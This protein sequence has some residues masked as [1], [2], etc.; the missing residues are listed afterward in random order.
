[1]GGGRNCGQGGAESPQLLV[2]KC[3]NPVSLHSFTLLLYYNSFMTNTTRSSCSVNLNAHSTANAHVLAVE[4]V[5]LR[6][7]SCLPYSSL[8]LN[9]T[10]QANT[11]ETPRVVNSLSPV[12]AADVDA[13]VRVAE[14]L[15]HLDVPKRREGH[16]AVLDALAAVGVAAVLGGGEGGRGGKVRKFRRTTRG[17]R[18]I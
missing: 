10:T 2:R 15:P 4:E 17:Q 5:Q 7:I 18:K 9:T 13:D 16:D 3:V 11:I 6:H 1:M 14:L 12:L 8:R